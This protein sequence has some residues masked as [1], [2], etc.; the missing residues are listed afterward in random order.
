MA[1]RDA[2]SKTDR[3]NACAK[4]S[5]AAWTRF[6]DSADAQARWQHGGEQVIRREEATQQ[7]RAVARHR[8]DVG[9]VV[10]EDGE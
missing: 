8:C 7:P 3:K 10:A 2:S 9:L 6:C 4:G 1:R 5:T